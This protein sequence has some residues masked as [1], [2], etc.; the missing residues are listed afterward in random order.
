MRNIRF[1]KFAKEVY[2]FSYF[3]LALL[4]SPLCFINKNVDSLL[5]LSIVQCFLFAVYLFRESETIS[6]SFLFWI[7]SH[8]FSLSILLIPKENEFGNLLPFT[9]HDL[10]VGYIYLTVLYTYFCHLLF[11]IGCV[12]INYFYKFFIIFCSHHLV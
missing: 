5:L 10:N 8:F 1:P 12:F 2:I 9:A 11:A 7:M 3:F 6:F 4:F